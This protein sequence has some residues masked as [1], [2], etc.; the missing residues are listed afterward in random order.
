MPRRPWGIADVQVLRRQLERQLSKYSLRIQVF[1]HEMKAANAE[2]LA[3]TAA[4]ESVVHLINNNLA[5]ASSSDLEK[6]IV[7]YHGR[8]LEERN[9]VQTLIDVS[10]RDFADR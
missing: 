4:W 1:S 6:L 7:E 9:R 5:G 2:L 3:N 10:Y 8:L